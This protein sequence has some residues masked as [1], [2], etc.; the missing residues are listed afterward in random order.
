[1]VQKFNLEAE[2]KMRGVTEPQWKKDQRS[3]K[4]AY[5]LFS[6]GLIGLVILVAGVIDLLR[7]HKNV[8]R[9]EVEGTIISSSVEVFNAAARRRYN[10]GYIVRVKYEFVDDD[11]KKQI[12][13]ATYPR[14]AIIEGIVTFGFF[15][16]RREIAAER[17]AERLA[18]GN[19]VTVLYM[20]GAE[21][22][23]WTEFDSHRGTV[24]FIET[25]C[26]IVLA[27]FGFMA[28]RIYRKLHPAYQRE[29]SR[30]RASS[31]S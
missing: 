1:V 9:Q 29:E 14:E 12:N 25:F 3:D 18:T 23:I 22:D 11:G 31:Q 13:V 8:G 16:Y 4:R 5:L 21:S 24:A 27:L 28:T 17:A 30:S 2:R 26:G 20:P 19:K 6:I 7:T 10:R 15:S